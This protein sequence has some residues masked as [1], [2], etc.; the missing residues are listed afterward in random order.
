MDVLVDVPWV[1]ERLDA[2][3]VLLLDAT[4]PPVG[5]VPK[6]DTRA[7][8]LEKH[9]PGAVFFDIDALSDR[10]TTLPHML[11]PADRF[12]TDMGA[13][14]VA[15]AG[16]DQ[17]GKT[18]VVYEQA[19][20]FSAPRAWW[21]LRVMGAADVRVLQGG[22]AAWEAAGL[23]LEQGEVEHAPQQFHAVLDKSQVAGLPDLMLALERGEQVVD[24]RSAGRFAG[25]APEPR[26]GLQSGHMPGALSVPYTELV[27]DGRLKPLPDMAAVFA[28]HGVHVER[29]VMT[30]CGSGV[31]AAVLALALEL[32]GAKQVRL[33]DGSWAEYASRPCASIMKG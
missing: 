29:P 21:M 1:A 4:L 13:L 31:T 30:T 7:R 16:P 8:Y 6:V 33:Y 9:L 14:G 23:P 25:S 3:E 18:L 5:V 10:D 20:V 15:S 11:P 19:G 26:A 2:G 12:A 27:A 24:A 28:A 17:G 32:C 22:L